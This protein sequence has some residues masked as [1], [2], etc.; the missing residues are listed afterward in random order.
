[1]LDLQYSY[2]A[3]QNNGRITQR[4]DAVSG[5]QVSYTYDSLNRLIQAVT[6]GPQYGLSWTYDGF[7]NMTAQQVTK[8]SGLQYQS[9]LQ[10]ADQPDRDAGLRLRREREPDGDAG[11]EHGV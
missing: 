10:R 4:T 9:E 7:G 8:G 11:A 6:T 1:V 5:E 3:G 2:T